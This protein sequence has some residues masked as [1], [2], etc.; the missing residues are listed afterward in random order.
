MKSLFHVLIPLQMKE[1]L[2]EEPLAT[3]KA[4]S[5]PFGVSASCAQ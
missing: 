2:E 1:S 3:S 5:E 4:V